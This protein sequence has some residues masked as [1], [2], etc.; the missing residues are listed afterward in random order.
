MQVLHVL[1]HY[2]TVSFYGSANLLSL[3]TVLKLFSYTRSL[4]YE[5]IILIVVDYSLLRK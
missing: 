2:T 3:S 5:V 1:S 4:S